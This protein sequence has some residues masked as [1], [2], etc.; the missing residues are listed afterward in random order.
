MRVHAAK[1]LGGAPSRL[2]LV[3][4]MIVDSLNFEMPTADSR[5]RMSEVRLATVAPSAGTRSRRQFC[6]CLI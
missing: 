6:D 3:L 1:V 5:L 2:L 4:P